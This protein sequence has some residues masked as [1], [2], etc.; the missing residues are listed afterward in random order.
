MSDARASMRRFGE[1]ALD[2]LTGFAPWVL[3]VATIAGITH[4]TSILAMPRLA[5]HDAFARIAA[6]APPHRTTPLPATAFGSGAPFD[7]PALAQGVCRFDLAKGPL[8][9]RST[10]IPETLMLLSF[11]SRYG[12]VF[13]SMT[14]R[15]ATRGRLD[16]LLLTRQQLDDVEAEDSEDELPQELRIV[17]PTSEGFLLFRSLA[18]RASDMDEANRRVASISCG[19]DAELKN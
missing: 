11:H 6:V 4:L 12:D 10:F 18:E 3:A 14:D 19:L 15:S 2:A 17:A 7:D 8:R 5:P 13:Y 1:R 16:V 9:L